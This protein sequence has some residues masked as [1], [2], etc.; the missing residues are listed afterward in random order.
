MGG[1][2][3]E[4][5]ALINLIPPALT[6]PA[7]LFDYEIMDNTVIFIDISQEINESTLTSWN[8]TFGDG[9][10]AEISSGYTEHTYNESGTYTIQLYVTNEYGQEG[11][12]HY[13]EITIEE[14]VP[15]DINNDSVTNIL[16]IVLLVSFIVGTETPT[17][18]ELY[19][20]DMNNDGILNILDVV[21]LV[22]SVLG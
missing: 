7:A 19:S 2:S 18:S 1:F 5:V 14:S 22:S 20:G 8:W 3:Y 21:M 13:E 15:G 4:Q 17:S 12:S 6:N 16:D 11:P 10:S 9:S